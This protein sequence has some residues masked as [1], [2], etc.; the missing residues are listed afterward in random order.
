MAVHTA[1]QYAG[2]PPAAYPMAIQTIPI[3]RN[4]LSTM[5]RRQGLPGLKAR[6]ELKAR[7]GA[8]GLTPV[9]SR[10]DLSRLRPLTEPAPPTWKRIGSPVNVNP[11]QPNPATSVLS[12]APTIAAGQI[13]KIEPVQLKFTTGQ[14]WAGI[15]VVALLAFAF[16]RK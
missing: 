15:A 16:F 8:Y 11:I 7:K 3:S 9:G 2:L 4:R 14:R 5:K 10:R 13:H 1:F 6:A 12:V